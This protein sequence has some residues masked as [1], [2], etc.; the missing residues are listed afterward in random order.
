M[1]VWME[2]LFELMLTK[3]LDWWVGVSVD[4][5]EGVGLVGVWMKC[6]F[7]LML[8]KELDWWACG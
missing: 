6:L 5:Y 2:C 4:A 1:C 3:K 7:E 8:T